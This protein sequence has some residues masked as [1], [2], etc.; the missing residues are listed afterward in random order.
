MP[1]LLLSLRPFF[2]SFLLLLAGCS[3]DVLRG[4]TSTA[5]LD[6]LFPLKP[7]SSWTYEYDDDRQPNTS[8]TLT[9]TVDRFEEIEGVGYFILPLQRDGQATG[10]AA[11]VRNTLTGAYFHA[12]DPASEAV[13]SGQFF[14]YPVSDGETY[15]FGGMVRVRYES[16]TVPAGTFDA[17]TYYFE[18]P[19]GAWIEISVVPGLGMVRSYHTG[20]GAV[21]VL[22]RAAVL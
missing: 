9:Y 3:T 2:F 14:K 22:L 5:S 19:E 15:D 21:T 13:G 6:P 1:R 16:V 12:F 4:A 11:A 10:E 20:T 17:I 7:A 18:Q 8:V